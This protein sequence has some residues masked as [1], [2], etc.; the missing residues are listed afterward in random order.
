MEII[1]ANPDRPDSISDQI[2]AA[3]QLIRETRQRTL[4]KLNHIIRALM[5]KHEI[6]ETDEA[7]EA[8]FSISLNTFSA[9]IQRVLFRGEHVLDVDWVEC[10]IYPTT[11][12]VE[13]FVK[14]LGAKSRG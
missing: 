9:D 4:V 7:L 3:K 12:E 11:E 10:E 2:E 13:A 8:N 14:L 1:P 5:F 6:S